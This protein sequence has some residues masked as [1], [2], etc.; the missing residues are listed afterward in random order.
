VAGIEDAAWSYE[1][2][3]PESGGIEGRLAFDGSK[4]EI[5]LG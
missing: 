4:A 2:P 5:T 1:Y 3:R